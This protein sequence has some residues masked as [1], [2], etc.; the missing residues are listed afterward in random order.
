MRRKCACLHGLPALSIGL[1]M[2]VLLPRTWLA[3]AAI[4]LL[5]VVSFAV[6]WDHIC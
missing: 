2:G 1:L 3:V 6:R 5:T 4:V